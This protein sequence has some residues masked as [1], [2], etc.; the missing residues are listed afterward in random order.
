[1]QIPPSPSTDCLFLINDLHLQIIENI[2]LKATVTVE[3][4]SAKWIMLFWSHGEGG[5]NNL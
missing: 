4:L 2:C 3:N 1:M 5:I